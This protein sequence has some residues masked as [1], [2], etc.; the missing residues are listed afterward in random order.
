[1]IINLETYG[2]DNMLFP[3]SYFTKSIS[4]NTFN[5]P[6]EQIVINEK[7]EMEVKKIIKICNTLDHRFADGSDS[8]IMYQTIEEFF[9][10]I[11]NFF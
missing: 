6:K 5:K 2:I 7:G 8:F 10:N 11:E 9:K 4:V 1:M 3:L